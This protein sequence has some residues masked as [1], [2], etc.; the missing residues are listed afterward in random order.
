MIYMIM[1]SPYDVEF[2]PADNIDNG[3]IIYYGTEYVVSV[4]S[5]GTGVDALNIDK[6]PFAK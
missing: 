6:N 4:G 1:T 2:V 5:F 3:G